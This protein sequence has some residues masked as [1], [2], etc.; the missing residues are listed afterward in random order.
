MS[1]GLFSCI[2]LLL[3]LTLPSGFWLWDEVG[4]MTG[5]CG[6]AQE[7]GEWLVEAIEMWDV[8]MAAD[9]PHTLE[10]MGNNTKQYTRLVLAHFAVLRPQLSPFASVL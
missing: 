8:K 7:T 9:C 10:C 1:F 6:K 4:A 2:T 5:G 3:N